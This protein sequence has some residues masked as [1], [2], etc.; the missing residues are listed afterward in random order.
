MRRPANSTILWLRFSTHAVQQFCD[1]VEELIHH[2]LFER[3]DCVISDGDV[4]G[5]DMGAAFG[6]IAVANVESL[7]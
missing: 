6:D 2:A 5:T 3:N 7:S 4:L 1:W